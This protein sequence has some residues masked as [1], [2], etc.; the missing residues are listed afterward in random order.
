[1]CGLQRL[2]PDAPGSDHE[3]PPVAKL[4]EHALGERERQRARGRRVRA[5]SGLRTSATTGR[6]RRAEEQGEDVA[7]RLLLHGGRERLSHLPQDL[8]LAEHE[9]VEARGHTAE[10]ARDVLA[11][12]DVE[13]I[14]QQLRADTPCA[15]ESASTSSSRAPRRRRSSCVELDAIAR[16]E[17]RVLEDGRAALRTEPER[18]DALAQLDGSRAVAETEAD[19]A[20]HAA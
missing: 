10:V 12:V 19:E 20:V 7:D 3:D 5:D 14:E 13:V 15:V 18:A 11:R 17:R 9:G 8:G 1:M 6:D 4:S 16:L 2:Q